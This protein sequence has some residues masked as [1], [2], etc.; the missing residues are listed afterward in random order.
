M[1]ED[2]KT[3]YIFYAFCLSFLVLTP[4]GNLAAQCPNRGVL[5][6]A[7]PI[8]VVG[9]GAVPNRSGDQTAALQSAIDASC[10]LASSANSPAVYIPAGQY[11]FTSLFIRCSGLLLYGDGTGG[12]GGGRGG[13]QLCSANSTTP[14]LVVGTP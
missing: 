9:C 11:T 10:E 12:L 14:M 8:N 5:P 2:V 1:I 13:T 6:S 3:R 7:A 4:H